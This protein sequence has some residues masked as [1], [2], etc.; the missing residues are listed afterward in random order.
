MKLTLKK[1]EKMMRENDGDI[2]LS[3]TRIKHLPKGLNVGGNLDLRG[4]KITS[5][6][7]DLQVGNKIF[8]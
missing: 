6:P 5:L 1:A 3:R 7:K 2:R 8:I 4:T